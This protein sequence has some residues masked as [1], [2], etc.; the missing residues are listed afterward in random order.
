ML[1]GQQSKSS[2]RR[3]S[4][5]IIISL[6]T[7]LTLNQGAAQA[8][9]SAEVQQLL[10]RQ[11][12]LREQKLAE[13]QQAKE[14][15]QEA[16]QLGQKVKSL[17]RSI[18]VTSQNIDDTQ[19]QIDEVTQ[20]IVDKEHEI[21]ATEQKLALEK[22]HQDEAIRTLYQLGGA[23]PLQVALSSTSISDVVQQNQF[24]LSIEQNVQSVIDQVITT[25]AKLEQDK[26]G[27]K[28]QEAKLADL[29]NQQEAQKINLAVQ[30]QQTAS[31]QADAAVEAQVATDQVKQ[32]QEQIASIEQKLRVLTATARW[33]S[34]VVSDS[35]AGWS[36]V[37]LNYSDTLGNSPYTVHDYGCLVTS[38]AMVATYYGNRV[39]PPWI[40][41]HPNFFSYGD[42]YVS[43]IASAIGLVQMS[44]RSVNWSVVD[45]ELDNG[46]PVIVSIYLPQ[47][48]AIN[49]DGSSHFIVIS[50]KSGS[51]NHYL[52]QDPLGSGRGYSLGQVRSMLTFRSQ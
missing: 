14:S 20:S 18:T 6:I 33:G 17:Q 31:Q 21:T 38:L 22:Q 2:V 9:T 39:S 16:Q 52:M 26:Q 12:Q 42:A 19:N 30:R 43:T 8:A 41:N 15:Q 3:I 5:L 44:S 50:G 1:S 28:D 46:H 7:A 25:K 51:G 32:L 36:Y 10:A 49:R 27:L 35:P 47:V 4:V 48:G 11:A 29:K 13:Q 23:D 34:D 40:A 45:S 24:L 37:Q